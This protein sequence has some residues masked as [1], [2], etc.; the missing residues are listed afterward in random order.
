[1]IEITPDADMK[2]QLKQFKDF[3]AINKYLTRYMNEYILIKSPE[4]SL[5]E[6]DKTLIAIGNKLDYGERMVFIHPAIF[7]NEL[8]MENAAEFNEKVKEFKITKALSYASENIISVVMQNTGDDIDL[9]LNNITGTNI[10]KIVSP[11]RHFNDINNPLK[12]VRGLK[13]VPI[14]EWM[15]LMLR[16]NHTI[17]MTIDDSSIIFS[18]KILGSLQTTKDSSLIYLAKMECDIPGKDC[19]CF[20]EVIYDSKENKG[21][22]VPE[23]ISY[24]IVYTIGIR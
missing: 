15:V 5:Y 20:K 18:K 19:W 13:Y 10:E 11:N 21:K 12:S 8:Y 9:Q 3:V 14:E 6:N 17:T 1:M 7:Y 23:Y 4:D 2:L 24:L 22:G 16:D